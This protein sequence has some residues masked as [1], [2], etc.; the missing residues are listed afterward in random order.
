MMRRFLPLVAF[1]ALSLA[2]CGPSDGQVAVARYLSDAEP[3]ATDLSETGARFETLMNVQ[4]DGLSWTSQEKAELQDIIAD[5]ESLKIRS[6]AIAVPAELKDIHA[7]MPQAI[8][9]MIDAMHI[10][11]DIAQD[12]SKVNDDNLNEALAKTQE[13]GDIAQKYVDDLSKLLQERYPELLE[14]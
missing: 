9:K 5:M 6:E 8:A 14:A 7:L 10:V 12:P 1:A 3:V 2:A 4:A 13:G 11:D